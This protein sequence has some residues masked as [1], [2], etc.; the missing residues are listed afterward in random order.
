MK[1]QSSCSYTVFFLLQFFV[2]LYEQLLM[3]RCEYL[4][5]FPSVIKKRFEKNE[6][7]EKEKK[8]K[9]FPSKMP[10]VISRII[11]LFPTRLHLIPLIRLQPIRKIVARRREQKKI[12][13]NKSERM[14]QWARWRHGMSIAVS[15]SYR[16][17]AVWKVRN[18]KEKKKVITHNSLCINNVHETAPPPKMVL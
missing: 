7:K 12:Y 3:F 5:M 14:R 4:Y 8:W 2:C 15:P 6:P 18:R 11:Y 9:Q 17:S 1:P 10:V 13:R 16:F